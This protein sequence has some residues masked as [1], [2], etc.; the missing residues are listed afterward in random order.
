MIIKPCNVVLTSILCCLIGSGQQTSAFPFFQHSPPMQTRQAHEPLRDGRLQKHPVEKHRLTLTVADVIEFHQLLAQGPRRSEPVLFSPGGSRYVFVLQHGDITR[1]GSWI[2]F[3][4]AGTSSLR[5]ASNL[6]VVRLFTRSTAEVRD[7]VKD[8]RWLADNHRISF[9]WDDGIAIPQVAVLDF[10]THKL[11]KLTE[12]GS[13]IVAYD[14]SGDGRTLIYTAETPKDKSAPARMRRSGFAVTDES[15]W[16]L[17]DDS[18]YGLL[19]R[20][21]YQTFVQDV[22][23]GIAH[24]LVEAHQKWMFPPN[25][26][27]FSPDGRY[28]ITKRPVQNPPAE[29]DLYTQDIFKHIH[30]APARS[31][32]EEANWLEQFNIVDVR[33]GQVRPLWQAPAFGAV[34][35]V[36]SPD[37]RYV[38]LGPTFLPTGRADAEGL[39]GRSVAVVEIRSG[40]FVQLAVGQNTLEYGY[41]PGRWSKD[42]V[43]ELRDP[44]EK[45]KDS[46]E[47]FKRF[48]GGWSRVETDKGDPGS[49]GKLQF[50]LKQ[51]PNTP[52]S[53]VGID[54]RTG[55]E[56]VIFEL[57]PTL[58]TEFTLGRV[59]MVHW[60]AT[61]GKPWTGMLYY[62]VGYDKE[63]RFP[64]VIQTHGYLPKEF[65]LNGSFT[66]AFAAQPLANLGIAVLQV[67][68]PDKEEQDSLA[69]PREVEISTAG[70]EG[71]VKHFTE[72]GLADAAKVGLVGFSRT[73]WHVAYMLTHSKLPIA[74]AVIADGIDGSY[75]Q[76]ALSSGVPRGEAE[77]NI[78]AAPFGEGLAVWLRNAPGFNADKIH[79]PLRME[80][81]SGPIF[82]ILSS[83]ELF[84]HLR[85]LRKPA[86]LYVIPDIQHGAHVL[87]N[88]RQRLASQGGTVDWFRFWLKGEEESDPSKVNQYARWRDMRVRWQA[89]KALAEAG[90]PRE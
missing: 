89:A 43:I 5:A 18:G 6:T 44:E 37:S 2:E 52:P 54:P 11:T 80:I 17:L 24:K 82:E 73:Y 39:L 61:D 34:R 10:R 49:E 42:D 15:V 85:Y 21:Q 74:A 67:G 16:S 68:G 22:A 19:T 69:T 55:K 26:L 63:R 84:A 4:S 27:N 32:P 83:W 65:S 23:T 75:L 86:E 29:W 40:D 9:L 53:L 1:N 35:A 77:R 72:I 41:A 46:K 71:A 78:G 62:P 13:P 12:H 64:F 20:D 8:L 88:P 7:L 56:Q 14:V 58:R 30:L 38:V 57:D 70:F 81:D 36:W 47:F 59:E 45:S 76:Y 50:E 25:V 90:G 79:T 33:N 28:A 31:H 66:T 60:T 3:Y 48:A 87:Q 51:D